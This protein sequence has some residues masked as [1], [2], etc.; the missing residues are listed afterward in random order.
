MPFCNGQPGANVA[1]TSN[2]RQR[3]SSQTTVTNQPL[4]AAKDPAPSAQDIARDPQRGHHQD[5]ESQPQQQVPHSD[6]AGSAL[7]LQDGLAKLQSHHRIDGID[8]LNMHT[9]DST[10]SSNVMSEGHEKGSH[11]TLLMTRGGRFKYLG[12]TSAS[13]WLKDVRSIITF[14]IS[15]GI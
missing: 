7:D 12:P 6:A 8:Q 10:S 4:A 2:S 5:V 9:G 11:G 14:G 3:S 1:S 15:V 13:E